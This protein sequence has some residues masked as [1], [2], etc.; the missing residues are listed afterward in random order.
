VIESAQPFDRYRL[1]VAPMLFMLAPGVADR[2]R[3]F[4]AGGGTLVLT[5]LSGVQNETGLVFRGG[6][7]GGGLREL[8]GVWVEEID[9]LYPNPSQRIVMKAG[10]PLG[11][12]GE[13]AVREYCELVHAE[14]ATVL[15][16]YASDFYEGRPCLTVNGVGSGRVYYLAARP[17]EEAFHDAFAQALVRDLGI[18]RCLD[19]TLPEGVSVQKRTGGGRTFLFVHNFK[20]VEQALDLTR[21]RFQEV[22]SGRDVTGRLALPAYGSFVLERL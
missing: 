17:A 13:H 21:G 18:A 5:Y 16:S 8:T 4:V 1:L 11:F 19:A 15:A 9:S 14:K 10:N 2:L 20:A 12:A 3:A 22:A 7:P 6:W